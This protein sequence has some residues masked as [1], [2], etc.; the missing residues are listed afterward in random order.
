M[1]RTLFAIALFSFVSLAHANILN[2]PE[3]YPTIQ[4]GMDAAASGDTVLVGPGVYVE[5]LWPSDRPVKIISTEGPALTFLR[6]ATLQPILAI[7]H[8]V[9]PGGELRGFTIEQSTSDNLIL[10]GAGATFLIADNVFTD[11]TTNSCIILSSFANAKVV[12][13]VFYGNSVGS[14]CVGLN[15]SAGEIINNTFVGNSRGYFIIGS[16]S[17]ALNNIVMNSTG[18]GIFG[19]SGDS[20]Y[21]IFWNNHP[22]YSN[23]VPGVHDMIT[24]P[25]FKDLERGDYSLTIQSPAVDAGSPLEEFN[26]PDGTRNDIGAYYLAERGPGPVNLRVS[27]IRTP[28]PTGLTMTWDFNG[29]VGQDQWSYEIEIGTDTN[30]TAAEF[31][32]T[33]PVFTSEGRF[34]LTDVVL[35]SEQVYYGRIRLASEQETGTWREFWYRPSHFP[36]IP[37]P[38]RPFPGEAVRVANVKLMIGNSSDS[39]AKYIRY[40]FEVFA[41]SDLVERVYTILELDAGV[42]FTTTPAI[43]GLQLNNDY[44]WRA[45]ALDRVEASDW[46]PPVRFS[47]LGRIAHRVPSQFAT[48][49]LAVDAALSGDSI[50]VAPGTYEESIELNGKGLV[51]IG[52]AGSAGTFWRSPGGEPC[53][54]I[55]SGD[56]YESE[57][58]GFTFA[59]DTANFFIVMNYGAAPLIQ[60]NV[61]HD[62]VSNVPVH[63]YNG[64][65]T[66]RKNVF[67]RNTVGS[68]CLGVN[69]GAAVVYNNTFDHNSRGLFLME[70]AIKAFNNIVTNSIDYGILGSGINLDYN[71]VWMNNPN[72]SNAHIGAGSVET[73]PLFVNSANGDLRLRPES[74]CI[75]AGIPDDSYTDEDG[76][77]SDMGALAHQFANPVALKIAVGSNDLMH[78]TESQPL[79]TWEYFDIAGLEQA[80]CELEIGTDSD[81]AVAEILSS[82]SVVTSAPFYQYLGADLQPSSMYWGRARVNN[83][84]HWGDWMEFKFRRNSPPA[85]PIPMGPVGEATIPYM[86]VELTIRKSTDLESDSVTYDYAI[87]ADADFASIVFQIEAWPDTVS[88]RLPGLSVASQY[89]WRARA[90]DGYEYSVWSDPES[91]NTRAGQTLR[92][93]EEYS[94]IQAAVNVAEDSD[95][96]LVGPGLHSGR[97]SFTGKDVVVSSAFGPQQTKL[98][99]GN[100]NPVVVFAHGD[101][102]AAILQGFTVEGTSGTQEIIKIDGNA[103]PTI[104]DCRFVD[105]VSNFVLIRVLS[106]KPLIEKSLFTGNVIGNACVGIN[107]DSAEIRNCTFDQN[108]RGF[109]AFGGAAIARNN[110]VT[111]SDEYGVYGDFA[112][113]SFNDVWENYP[114]YAGFYSPSQEGNISEDPDFASPADLIYLLQSNSPCIDSGDPNA[115]LNDPDG[116]RSDMGAYHYVAPEFNPFALQQP[117][118]RLDEALYELWPQFSWEATATAIPVDNTRYR[119]LLSSDS[120]FAFTLSR[121]SLIE[122][123]ITLDVP[124]SWG[125][126]YWWKVLAMSTYGGARWSDEVFTF[127]TMTLGDADGSGQLNISDIV[128]LI[129]FIFAQGPAPDPLVSGDLNCDGRINMGDAVQLVNYMFLSGAAPCD[130]FPTMMPTMDFERLE[131]I[132]HPSD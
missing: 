60:Y 96:V 116:T 92:V 7:D 62:L 3:Q 112:I 89:W 41:D 4:A 42:D 125:T 37:T 53:I 12:R 82:G 6:S 63:C 105:N 129:N 55:L 32:S 75:N 30:W 95:T 109:F 111:N 25:L 40:D 2:V 76:T 58:R 52:E 36:T 13:N 71:C 19:G 46:S 72:Y 47:T 26:D 70:P 79:I 45:R 86:H 78:V 84:D 121:D 65:P 59:S 10:I 100:D 43:A 94:T 118:N 66:I 67:Y 15:T 20:D 61:F 35:S 56:E 11:N 9:A 93:P 77:R 85:R 97:I 126:R 127:R 102:R 64:T 119:F 101:S 38:L 24:D 130:D 49:Q 5:N 8:Y 39:D 122:P 18:Y 57:V 115:T 74:P 81:W 28:D 117:A 16:T 90:F 104:R 98:S 113:F 44:F 33:G 17:R 34:E 69:D 50:L 103:S 99:T 128:F 48:I 54:E 14:A 107:Q 123:A 91:F 120:L 22:D 51:L 110:I 1:R 132:P 83:G 114:D 31:W 80:A 21:N 108:S 87:A 88:P 27:I 106:G 68:A 131:S 73:D 29:L 124:L 23:S